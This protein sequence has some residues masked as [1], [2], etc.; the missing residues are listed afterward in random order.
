[1]ENLTPMMKQYYGIK[2]QFKKE[3]L[4]F[5]MG[6]FYEMFAEDAKKAS[7][8]LNIALTKRT[9]IPMCGIPYHAK[10][11][12]IYKLIKSGLKVAICDQLEDPSLCKGIVKRGVTEVITPGT[13]LDDPT[14]TKE[15]LNNFIMALQF[16]NSNNTLAIAYADIATGEFFIYEENENNIFQ[17]IIDKLFQINPKE[18]ILPEPVKDNQ[19]F[20][21]LLKKYQKEITKNYLPQYRF[22]K[23]EGEEI[24]KNLLKVKTLKGYNIEDKLLAIGSAGSLIYYLKETQLKEISHLSKIIPIQKNDYMALNETTIKNLE[25]VKNTKDGSKQ[26]TLFNELNKSNT[27]MGGRLL[28]TWILN[29]LLNIGAIKK[30]Q[31]IVKYFFDNPPLLLLIRTSLKKIIDIER[32][33]GKIA[34]KKISPREITALKISLIA[35]EE[36]KAI[37]SEH[38]TLLEYSNLP[39]LKR[40]ISCIENA[41]L[42]EPANDFANGS[43]IKNGYNNDLDKLRE[44]NQEGKDYLIKLQ[45]SEKT[46]LKTNLKI[47]YNKV[48]GYFIEVSKSNTKNIPQHYIKKQSLVNSSR[49]TIPELA[50]YESKILNAQEKI[51]FLEKQLFEEVISFLCEHLSNIKKLSKLIAKLDVL[52]GFAFIALNKNY[53]M[54]EISSNGGIFISEGRHPVV[55][56]NLKDSEFIP[57]DLILNK[58]KSRL[59][60]I[61]GPNMAGKS[62]YLRQT[63]LLIIMAQIGSFIPVGS[64]ELSL[65]DRIFTRIGASDNLARGESTFLVEM[66]ETAII[67]NNATENS[68]IIMDEIGRGTS[69]YDGL[70]IAWSIVEYLSQNEKVL[71]KVLFATH[72]H[73][74]TALA[75]E[76]GIECY[77]VLVKEWGDEIIFLHKVKEGSASKSYGIQVARLAG[78]PN[79]VINRAKNI[80][81]DLENKNYSVEEDLLN[82]KSLKKEYKKNIEQFNLF[83]QHYDKLANE[84]LKLDHN[85][86]LLIKKI[87]ELQNKV[88][89][90]EI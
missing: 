66:I 60:L 84:I 33:I 70:S 9:N 58:D 68:L 46:K 77:Q 83:P 51:L 38:N 79:E 31:Q 59:L 82:Y 67:L 54:P 85:S 72:Y 20:M 57:N 10:D 45:N 24:L 27:A 81:A 2:N 30:R 37:L 21:D 64:A 18:L 6:D 50:E 39:N 56:N 52:S 63:A 36:V 44:F 28:Y 15:Q 48:L 87:K 11:N 73:E 86:P 25:L 43:V 7:K 78:L 71:G 4:F 1:M 74:L 41:I 62:T 14:N 13:M 22:D 34:L 3:I 65:V 32:L 42:D 80:L 23:N 47:K 35:C 69:T 76:E 17:A 55:E 40:I 5:R 75:K 29:P 8:I 19:P 61:T 12:Y 53:T 49:Y 90:G 89:R 16:K 26:Y 88:R